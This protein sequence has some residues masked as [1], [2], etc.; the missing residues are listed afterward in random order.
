MITL[1]A[2]VNTKAGFE[3][4]ASDHSELTETKDYIL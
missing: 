1:A 3:A 4:L 2:T